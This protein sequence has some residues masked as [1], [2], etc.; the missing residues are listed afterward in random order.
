MWVRSD[1]AEKIRR[2]SA[3]LMQEVQK[4]RKP[5]DMNDKELD[6]AMGLIEMAEQLSSY[7][8]PKAK[9]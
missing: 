5:E 8:S 7:G 4:L 2:T 3:D 9:T 6:E 1:E